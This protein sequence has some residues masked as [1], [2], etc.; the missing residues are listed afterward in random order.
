MEPLSR[1]EY[2]FNF[3]DEG[4]NRLTPSHL[5][6]PAGIPADGVHEVHFH[7][8]GDGRTEMRMAEHGYTTAEDRDLSRAGL[9]QCF[10]KMERSLA[11]DRAE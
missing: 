7:D 9:E 5:G 11:S 3:S 10:D 8:L 6:M 1:I 4:G 2:V